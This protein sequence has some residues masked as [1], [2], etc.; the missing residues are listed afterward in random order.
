[1]VRRIRKTRK[2]HL[3]K[4]RTLKNKS[5]RM[6]GGDDFKKDAMHVI[7]KSGY[8]QESFVSALFRTP[9]KKMDLGAYTFMVEGTRLFKV[10]AK[11]KDSNDEFK[12]IYIES[13]Y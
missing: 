7:K 4:R 13:D 12:E 8:S 6:H 10:S 2:T 11:L 3:K 9:D 1:M 5:K